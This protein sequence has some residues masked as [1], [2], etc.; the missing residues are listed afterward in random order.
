MMG[1]SA[2]AKRVGAEGGEFPNVSAYF[3]RLSARPA[4]ASAM[5]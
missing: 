1:Y 5:A 2:L 3:A 4:F